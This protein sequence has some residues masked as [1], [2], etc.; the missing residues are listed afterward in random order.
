MYGFDQGVVE[1]VVQVVD[2]YCQGVV[3]Y[4]VGL[5]VNLVG[6]LN[7]GQYLVMVLQQCL[8]QGVFVVWQGDCFV[9]Q[10]EMLGGGF[11]V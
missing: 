11:K 2:V 3:F 9:V 4:V 10:L 8:Q 7:W 1:F 6:E 5:V